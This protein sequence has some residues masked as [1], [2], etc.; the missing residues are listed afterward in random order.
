[1]T[2]LEHIEIIRADLLDDPEG[3]DSLWSNAFLLRALSEG[4][5]EIAIRTLCLS[6]DSTEDLAVFDAAPGWN[7]LHAKILYI[8]DVFLA[9]QRLDFKSEYHLRHH[10]NWDYETQTGT[11]KYYTLNG[12]RLRLVPDISAATSIVLATKRLPLVD[13]QYS[14]EPE[15]PA[16]Y[17]PALQHYAAYRAYLKPDSQTFDKQAAQTHLGIFTGMVGP[18]IDIK[19]QFARKNRLPMSFNL[20]DSA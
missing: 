18:A 4:E 7:P 1:M 16:E 8:E 9:G 11:A 13:L 6:D 17:Q 5:R 15:I 14:S 10:Y 20:R 3:D 12:N 2:A 19:R